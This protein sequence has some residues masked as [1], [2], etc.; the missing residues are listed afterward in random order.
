MVENFEDKDRMELMAMDGNGKVMHHLHRLSAGWR[1]ADD[2]AI[3]KARLPSRQDGVGVWYGGLNGGEN[4][5]ASSASLPDQPATI[6]WPRMR[7]VVS[8]AQVDHQILLLVAII[9]C[10][11]VWPSFCF[12]IFSSSYFINS[13]VNPVERDRARPPGGSPRA[14]ST[15][16]WKRKTTTKS[17]SSATPSTI[18]RRS[19]PTPKS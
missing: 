4:I 10:S 12:V 11:V 8:L 19:L 17:A 16:G 13:I 2:A 14:T 15:P 7:Y 3:T 6:G 5:M 1:A 9:C 18:W